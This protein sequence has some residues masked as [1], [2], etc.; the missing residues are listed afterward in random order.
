MISAL[1]RVRPPKELRII[2]IGGGLRRPE[3]Q[4]RISTSLSTQLL[5]IIYTWIERG[6]Q[7]QA[8]SRLAERNDYLL[9]DIGVS[10]AEA[11]HEAA[12]VL[13]PFPDI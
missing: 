1:E 2:T 4:R 7:R 13:G 6:R 8:L 11:L 9:K 5:A 12:K 10:R 3:H